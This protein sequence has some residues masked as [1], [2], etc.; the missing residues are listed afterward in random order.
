MPIPPVHYQQGSSTLSSIPEGNSGTR[1][2]IADGTE[3]Y[4]N[5]AILQGGGSV[6]LNKYMR[7]GGNLS[8]G[9]GSEQMLKKY[10]LTV[11]NPTIRFFYA[12][13]FKIF[14]IFY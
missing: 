10:D 14:K 5:T 6:N 4:N 9:G 11:N 2:S 12:T 13:V 7:L 3:L 8:V 1:V